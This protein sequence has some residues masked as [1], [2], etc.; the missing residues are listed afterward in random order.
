MVYGEWENPQTVRAMPRW[1]NLNMLAQ[2]AHSFKS[3]KLEA[4]GAVLD[5]LVK[6][7]VKSGLGT[8]ER[9]FCGSRTCV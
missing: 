3:D 8:S 6:S 7:G 5:R 1:T 4:Q 9:R 2:Y